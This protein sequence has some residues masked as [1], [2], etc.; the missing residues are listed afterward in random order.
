MTPETLAAALH[1]AG[2][3]TWHNSLEEP[4]PYKNHLEE[5]E[6]IIAAIP[7]T[8]DRLDHYEERTGSDD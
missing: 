4:Y 3:G 7:E 1:E 5:A 6:A 2:V 8:D